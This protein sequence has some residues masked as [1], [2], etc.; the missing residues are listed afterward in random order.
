MKN[1]LKELRIA[2]GLTQDQLGEK[3]GVCKQY[4]SGWESGKRPLENARA[5]TIISICNA[6]GC[7][8][9]EL[10]AKDF[11]Y[12]DEGRLIVDGLYDDPHYPNGYVIDIQGDYYILPVGRIAEP[13]E[14]KLS[15][16]LRK[17]SPKAEKV[18]QYVYTWYKIVPRDG[19]DV[20]IGR[21]ITESEFDELKSRCNLTDDDISS[22]FVEKV[23]GIYGK[24]AKT[25]TAV[26]IHVNNAI[27]IERELRDK[28][29]EVG[30]V[31]AGRVN[32][33]VK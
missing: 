2:A 28:G 22:E 6:L 5:A 15:P 31:A 10:F 1:K 21:A 8:Q 3:I 20:E 13:I 4:I 33:R 7:E 26:Q 14:S 32:I 24:Y 17:V 18:P 23:G 30:N 12:D 16:I 19:F 9:N 25:Y 29:I 11:E 27:E